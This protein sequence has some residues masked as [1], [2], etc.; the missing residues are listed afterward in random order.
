MGI[1]DQFRLDGKVAVVTGG[2]R[3]LGREISVGLAEAGAQIAVLGRG[4]GPCRETVAAI[5]DGGGEAEAFACDVTDW[6]KVDAV[7]GSVF[8][9]FGRVDILVNN[10]VYLEPRPLLDCNRRLLETHFSTNVY[11]P[12]ATARAAVS[13]VAGAYPLSIV[14]ISSIGAHSPEPSVGPYN[15][16]KAALENLTV[17]MAMEW[18]EQQVRANCVSPGTLD[19]DLLRELNKTMPEIVEG[20]RKSAILKRFGKPRE[21][22]S[23]VLLLASDAGSF[24]TGEVFQ[25]SGGR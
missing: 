25:V 3:G 8:D 13:R 24:V 14:N 11:G 10:A 4:L 5:A 21:V 12:L 7:I 15:A 23:A 22:V 6:E 20:L 19:S 18:M 2:G 16:S 1:L 9:R 17:V